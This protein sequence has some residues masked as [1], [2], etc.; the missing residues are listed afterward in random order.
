MCILRPLAPRSLLS[1]FSG[2]KMYPPQLQCTGT[3]L[4]PEKPAYQ[5]SAEV[6]T[7]CTQCKRVW[8][9]SNTNST[10][11]LR[12]SAGEDDQWINFEDISTLH[13]VA[14]ISH[15]LCKS[16]FQSLD[17]LVDSLPP[18]MHPSKSK[19]AVRS[20]SAPNITTNHQLVAKPARVLVVDDN[21]LQSRIHG[22][23]VEQAGVPC[24]ITFSATEAIEM[25]QKYSYSLILMDLMMG[26]MDGWSG[27]KSIRKVLL[28]S[29]GHAGL[30]RIVAVTGLHID[31][32]LVG[33]CAD[34]GM[35][36]IVQKPVSPAVLGTLLRKYA[37]PPS[38]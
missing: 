19:V 6:F 26:D 16:C 17:A 36:D 24:D 28:K 29:I 22:R 23:M 14:N 18:S 9:P 25:V 13:T 21:K 10:P 30:P 8:V 1:L 5:G 38:A 27:S 34:A 31:A 33:A 20:S 11:S 7:V 35:D 4:A 3:S 32:K 15:G 12:V 2:A 37:G